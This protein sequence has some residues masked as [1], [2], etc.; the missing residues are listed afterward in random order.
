MGGHRKLRVE[1]SA[2]VTRYFNR[3]NMNS[4]NTDRTVMNFQQLLSQSNDKKFSTLHL[5]STCNRNTSFQA[6]N[7]YFDV[8]E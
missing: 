8:S 4:A 7:Q 6:I 3:L 2:E 5:L 1:P